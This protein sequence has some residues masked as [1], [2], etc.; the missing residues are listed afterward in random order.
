MANTLPPQDKMLLM[1]LQHFV[2]SAEV[3]LQISYLKGTLHV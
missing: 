1:H 3:H 2:M